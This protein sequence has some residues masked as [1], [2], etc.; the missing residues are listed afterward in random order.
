MSHKPDI[1]ATVNVKFLFL[2][3]VATNW[4][5]SLSL[6]WMISHFRSITSLL[7]KRTLLLSFFSVNDF[8]FQVNN[9][10]VDEAYAVA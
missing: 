1:H 3:V 4:Y 10:L 2:L 6:V 9:E 8:T 7:M 5:L